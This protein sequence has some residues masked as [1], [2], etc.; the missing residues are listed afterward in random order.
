MN[1]KLNMSQKCDLASVKA[2]CRLGYNSKGCSQHLVGSAF[3][4]LFCTCEISGA[5]RPVLVSPVQE[6]PWH[7]GVSPEGPP[8][9][10]GGWSTASMNEERLGVAGLST[11]NKS[12]GDTSLLSPI[13]SKQL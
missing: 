5:L 9:R 3:S 11:L 1:N 2:S 12:S 7:S 10:L 4:S 8:S 6:R 13:P